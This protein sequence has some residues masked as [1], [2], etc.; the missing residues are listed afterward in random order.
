[1]VDDG[2]NG[3]ETM[4][5]KT[6]KEHSHDD[7]KGGCGQCAECGG[8]DYKVHCTLGGGK[9]WLFFLGWRLWLT[10]KCNP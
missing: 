3:Y 5:M 4:R 6:I 1:V 9:K 2:M 8:S 10:A 7:E